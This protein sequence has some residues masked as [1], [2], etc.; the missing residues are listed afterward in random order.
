MAQSGKYG[1]DAA[2]VFRSGVQKSPDGPVFSY[3]STV[4]GSAGFPYVN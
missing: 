2:A 4:I 3:E 1:V